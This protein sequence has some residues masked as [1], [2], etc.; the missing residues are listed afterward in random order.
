MSACRP[1][2]L[3]LGPPASAGCLRV[4]CAALSKIGKQGQGLWPARHRRERQRFEGLG[5]HR[6]ISHDGR[7]LHAARLTHSMI[8]LQADLGTENWCG[9]LQEVGLPGTGENAAAFLEA[10]VR[11]VNERCW[12]SLSMALFIHPSTQV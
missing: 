6:A 4:L 11:M 7:S 3:L 12:G 5:A 2:L 9:V 8:C 10:S 1:A